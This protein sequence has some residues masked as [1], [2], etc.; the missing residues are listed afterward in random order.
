MLFNSPIFLFLFLPVTLAGFFLFARLAGRN[1]A[2]GFLL[3]ACLIFYAYSSVFNFVLFVAAVIANFLFG[4]AI[5]HFK[6]NTRAWLI[7]GIVLNLCLIGYFKYAGL[8]VSSV[9]EVF[10]LAFLHLRADQLSGRDA[11]KRPL[12]T[13]GTPSGAARVA[14]FSRDCR[15]LRPSPES[16]VT[17]HEV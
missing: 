15:R 8:I 1:A 11:P 17:A 6:R 12:R 16:D 10:S 5:G 9:N 3:F 2:L 13:N 7:G 14:G 4:Y